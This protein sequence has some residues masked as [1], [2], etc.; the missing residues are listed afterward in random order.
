M[1]MSEAEEQYP[2]FHGDGYGHY[3]VAGGHDGDRGLPGDD[4]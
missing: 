2:G 3:S 1:M 4:V